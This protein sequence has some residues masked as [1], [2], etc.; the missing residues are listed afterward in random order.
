MTAE[1]ATDVP[2]FGTK[3][4]FAIGTNSAGTITYATAVPIGKKVEIGDNDPEVKL[5]IVDGIDFSTVKKR[6]VN[7]DLGTFSWTSY[8][9]PNDVTVCTV[10]QGFILTPPAIPLKFTTTFNDGYTTPASEVWFGVLTKF[11]RK[12][13]GV[14]DSIQYECEAAITDSDVLTPGTP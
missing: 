5:R 6:A 14:E 11:T 10:L 2:V 13:G 8:F 4:S 9:D 1:I 7:T 12:Y 3:L